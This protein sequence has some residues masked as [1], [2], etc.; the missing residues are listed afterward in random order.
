MIK[1]EFFDTG[2][3]EFGPSNPLVYFEPAPA[4]GPPPETSEVT[5]NS[6]E[7]PELINVMFATD[8]GAI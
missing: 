3:G 2:I 1:S 4:G 6:S 8:W 7:T 5:F